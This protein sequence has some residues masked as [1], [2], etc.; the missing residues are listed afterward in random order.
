MDDKF[1]DMAQRLAALEARQESHE[2]RM[3]ETVREM[4]DVMKDMQSTVKAGNRTVAAL[5]DKISKWE[6]KFGGVIF[7]VS[8]LWAFLTGLPETIINWVKTFGGVK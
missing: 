6:G 7:A 3:E 8:C 1:L 5:N 2:E 4:R